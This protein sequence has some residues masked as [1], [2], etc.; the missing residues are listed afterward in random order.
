M[1]YKAVLENDETLESVPY[2]YKT[3]LMCAKVAH[4]YALEIKIVPEC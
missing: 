2:Q 1:C 4:N 3:Q